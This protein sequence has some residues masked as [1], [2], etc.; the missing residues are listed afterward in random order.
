MPTYT[1]TKLAIKES[2]DEIKIIEN[3][4]KREK[5]LGGSYKAIIQFN[6]RNGKVRVDFVGPQKIISKIPPLVLISYAQ[7]LNK[8]RKWMNDEEPDFPTL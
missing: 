5:P 1:Q 2:V 7:V 8:V 4:I 6:G 3:S